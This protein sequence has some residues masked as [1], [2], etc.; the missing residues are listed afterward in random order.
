MLRKF[1]TTRAP[2]NGAGKCALLV[3]EEFAFHQRFGHCGTVYGHKRTRTSRAQVMNGSG[4][5]FFPC[6]AF[7][8][9]QDCGF[10]GSHLPNQREYL[11][12]GGRCANQID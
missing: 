1:K 8:V 6:T 2:F 11:L 4:D 7:A 12:H 9:D 10:A 3:T 5:Q